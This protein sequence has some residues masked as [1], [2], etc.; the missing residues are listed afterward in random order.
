MSLNNGDTTGA[1]NA[2]SPNS[3]TFQAHGAD[4]ID[5][6]SAAFISD[7]TMTRDG[8][9]LILQTPDGQSIT[10]EGYF[11]ADPA[12]LLQAEDGSTL[13]P[14]LVEAFAR[15][16]LQFAAG[17]SANDES[18]VGAIE[19][20]SGKAT[21]TRADGTIETITAGT[22]IYQG[23]IIET[24]GDGAVNIVF[25]DETSMAISQNAKVAID[26]YTFDPAS[27]SGTTNISVLRGLFVFTSG[28]IGRDDPDDVTI[29]TP[30]GSIGIR[31]TIIAGEII[32]GGQSNISVL[33]GAI[34]I[35]NGT[36]EVTLSE[37]FETVRLTGFDKPMQEIGVVPASDISA[38][39]HSVGTVLPSLFTV[40]QDSVQEQS[41]QT[42]PQNQA[43]QSH[44]PSDDGAAKNT[45]PQVQD[46]TSSSAHDIVTLD[47]R[48]QT[49]LPGTPAPGTVPPS[50][51]VDTGTHQGGASHTGAP[52][53]TPGLPP[54]VSGTDTQPPPSVL[55]PA[56]PPPTTTPPVT[57]PPG[58][59]FAFAVAA[60]ATPDIA[61]ANFIVARINPSETGTGAVYT[62]SNGLTISADGYFSIGT[63]GGNPVVRLTTTGAQH[64]ASS[65]DTLQLGGFTINASLP[66]NRTGTAS[67]TVTVHDANTV[68][69]NLSNPASSGVTHITDS[70]N[71]NTGFSIAAFG[72][73]NND[74]FDDVI[75]TKNMTT[76]TNAP[77]FILRGQ[78]GELGDATVSANGSISAAPYPTTTPAGN[79]NSIVAG[80]GD[81]NGDGI[82][83]YLVGQSGNLMGGL[84]T[85]N[86]YIISGASGTAHTYFS[87]GGTA[88]MQIG[89]S[90]SGVGDF[91]NDGYADV[92]IGA[93]GAMGGNG[94]A[95]FV[96]GSA[97]G[98][99]GTLYPTAT[100]GNSQM[101][102]GAST[103][104]G[105]GQSVRGIGDINGDGYMDFA[106]GAPGDNG[107]AGSVEIV[108]GHKNGTSG[109]PNGRLTGTMGAGFGTE[110]LA[111]GDINGD[112]YS[113]ILIANADNSGRIYL[114][115]NAGQQDFMLEGSG[116]QINGAG[117]IG[118]FN[119]DGFD[120][121]VISL[122]DDTHSKM[123]VVY[124]KEGGA[125]VLN[126]DYLK[127]P[128][129][130]FEMIY[131]GATKH[132]S[133]LEI[134]GVG[135][136]NGD[137]RADFAIGVPDLNGSAAGNG[138][139]ILVYGRD[140][141]D[142][143][144]RQNAASA[145]N[146][147]IVGT[148]AN[149]TLS[150]N[151]FDHVSINA[152]AGN[153]AI[154]ISNTTFRSINGG[155]G[156]DSLVV[157]NSLNFGNINFEQISGIERLQFGAANQTIT[158]TLENI[159][160][161]LKSS[162]GF[163]DGSSHAAGYLKISSTDLANSGITG[164]TLV[165]DTGGQMS[166][167]GA[168]AFDI[169]AALERYSGTSSVS[170]SGS[171][172]TGMQGSYDSFKIGGYTL[173]I[174]NN[175]QVDIQ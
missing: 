15:S 98:L 175:I 3:Q 127:D 107:G 160:N 166:A 79:L 71:H 40:I 142:S 172:N 141:T 16:P 31:G 8:D 17:E 44:T 148:A 136:I 92:V 27:E 84:P 57:T 12:P 145:N 61:D 173:L 171:G 154:N 18:P 54:S 20:V 11:S 22:P 122:A 161:L 165:I 68:T 58:A 115:N 101:L 104:A 37:Q 159:F 88:G 66:D 140:S 143:A 121:F 91:N 126:F 62:F 116:Y 156:F 125:P 135:D 89:A 85:G 53:Q 149:D 14:N 132:D 120:D 144:P 74:G 169:D 118:D 90:V 52:A 21:V 4:R 155:G 24:D 41:G 25:I 42:P 76:V 106:I 81:F 133:M 93:P 73:V 100:S 50:S 82:A 9:D 138:G 167:T 111:L 128:N 32:P 48:A 80:I 67:A 38:R 72:D 146:Q 1:A 131:Q 75:F 19:E 13:T 124:G 29:Q 43:P 129:N 78:A 56:T 63:D 10:I 94:A 97:N 69:L 26:E 162:D 28:L 34:V 70:E 33:E 39:F 164:S 60:I 99:S 6:P 102:T 86:A 65:L 23:D 77:V 5:L 96:Q 150:D 151:G 117:A 87:G 47:G 139:M 170:A 95:Y 123:Y 55:A 157:N 153:D 45:S 7:A 105:F 163:H 103:G 49:G 109:L 174:E 112:G 64:L 130:A 30:V 46:N 147:G 2:A 137:G 108:Y 113:D 119:G 59:P 152:G 110:I 51:P 134:T 168:S 35:K 114:G 158:L 36:M 83:D